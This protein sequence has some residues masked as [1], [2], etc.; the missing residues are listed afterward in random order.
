MVHVGVGA[1][2]ELSSQRAPQ[3]TA[4]GLGRERLIRD[5]LRLSLECAAFYDARR[6]DAD[7]LMAVHL[8]TTALPSGPL[9]M[10]ALLGAAR[11]RTARVWAVDSPFP[12]KEVLRRRGYRWHGGDDGL[13]RA[14][15]RDV[16]EVGAAAEVAWL[17]DAVY[18]GVPR[19]RLQLFDARIRHSARVAACPVVSWAQYAARYAARRSPPSRVAPGR[20]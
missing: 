4:D 7:C 12:T 18:D 11:A 9:A 14:W 1:I 20:A 3:Q 19:A 10:A 16:P 17:A 6:A 15:W 5:R 2:E 8:L 13:P